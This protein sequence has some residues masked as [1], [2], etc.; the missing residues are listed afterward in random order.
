MFIAPF[1][2][3]AENGAIKRAVHEAHQQNLR[4]FG[5]SRD[6]FEAKKIV[7]NLTPIPYPKGG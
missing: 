5:I 1:L 7:L 3:I 2:T 6:I 4:I